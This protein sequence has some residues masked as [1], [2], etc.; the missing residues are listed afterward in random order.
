MATTE[1]K[2]AAHIELAKAAKRLGYTKVA[3]KQDPAYPNSID[4]CLGWDW[5][6]HENYGKLSDLQEQMSN[7]LDIIF[8]L[9]ADV[10]GGG[11]VTVWS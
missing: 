7:K 8:E 6:E 11:V 4:L 1:E 2:L 3:V 9:C 10:T 5:D